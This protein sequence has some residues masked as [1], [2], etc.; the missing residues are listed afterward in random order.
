M[1]E[2]PVADRRAA[3]EE[4]VDSTTDVSS[5]EAD[6][7]ILKKAV[8]SLQKD[9]AVIRSGIAVLLNRRPL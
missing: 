5:L 9:I 3:V 1:A 7:A 6:V 8:H 2:Q 4:K